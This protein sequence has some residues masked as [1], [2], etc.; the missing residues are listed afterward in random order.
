MK[1]EE[2]GTKQLFGQSESSETQ[3]LS[4]PFVWFVRIFCHADDFYAALV[5]AP[6]SLSVSPSPARIDLDFPSFKASLPSLT[7]FDGNNF[8]SV[9]SPADQPQQGAR[10]AACC[11]Y[12]QS[13]VGQVT[14]SVGVRAETERKN[15]RPISRSLL[16]AGA[17]VVSV[18]RCYANKT[19]APSL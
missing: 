1:R 10:H 3:Y 19:T 6:S 8:L 18:R 9:S 4:P 15:W 13:A 16:S 17:D 11:A 14:L 5:F 12:G 2:S 7:K